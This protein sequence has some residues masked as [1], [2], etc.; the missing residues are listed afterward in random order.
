M[1][2]FKTWRQNGLFSDKLTS[3][4]TIPDQ[5]EFHWAMGGPLKLA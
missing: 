2:C 3:L 1:K 4:E 5:F